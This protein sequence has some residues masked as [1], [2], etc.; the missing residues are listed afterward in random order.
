MFDLAEQLASRGLLADLHTAYLASKAPVALSPAVRTAYGT[1]ARLLVRRRLP[2][3]EL[4][5]ALDWQILN[6]FDRTVAASLRPC[7]VFVALSGM[8]LRSLAMAKRGGA[9]TVCE[10]GSSH[11]LFQQ[12][13]LREEFDRWGQP[14][15]GPDPRVVERELREYELCDRIAVPSEFVRRTFLER[16]V[17]PERLLTNPYGV[18]VRAFHPVPSV[19]E[20]VFRILFAGTASLRKGIP[21][22]LK[23]FQLLKGRNLELWLAG[24]IA[25]EVTAM[26]EGYRDKRITVLGAVPRGELYRTY[27][28]AS[29]TVLPSLEEGLALVQAQ[30]IACG[31]PVI[32]TPNS[33]AE[34]L[35]VDGRHGFIVP[36]RSPEKL[37]AALEALISSP[38]L[39]EEMKKNCLALAESMT[40]WSQYGERAVAHYRGLLQ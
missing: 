34:D 30:S 24:T 18:D 12:Q 25:P 4:T 11:I 10:R 39:L 36:P 8:C 38:E 23:A 16:G 2:E 9:K 40:G 1:L 7:D 6:Q 21:Y 14:Y 22:L 17:A 26:I 19:K 13:I 32:S 33:G 28:R 29:V 15:N 5:R 3:G 27:G 20:D 37:A 31:V 35:F